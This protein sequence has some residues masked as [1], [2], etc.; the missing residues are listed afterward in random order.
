MVEKSHKIPVSLDLLPQ[1]EAKISSAMQWKET[2]KKLFISKQNPCK[3]LEVFVLCDLY[4]LKLPTA[5]CS[6]FLHLSDKLG[7]TLQCL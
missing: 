7:G 4:R 5:W 2:A 3:L 6:L 1:L